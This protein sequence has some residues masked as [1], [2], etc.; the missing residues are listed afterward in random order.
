MVLYCREV[1]VWCHTGYSSMGPLCCLRLGQNSSLPL[2]NNNSNNNNYLGKKHYV[3]LMLIGALPTKNNDFLGGRDLVGVG[4][5]NQGTDRDGLG[6]KSWS[7]YTINTNEYV[8]LNLE[9]E[10][11]NN[12]LPIICLL[13]PR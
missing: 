8:L 13:I 1:G 7:T 5:V 4:L 3:V 6:H 10:N 11:R 2:N 12:S 9:A